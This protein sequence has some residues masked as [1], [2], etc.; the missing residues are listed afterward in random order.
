MHLFVCSGSPTIICLRRRKHASALDCTSKW[1]VNIYYSTGFPAFDARSVCSFGFPSSLGN[2]IDAF[3]IRFKNKVNGWSLITRITAELF[4]TH[5]R[6]NHISVRVSSNLAIDASA[7]ECKKCF[8][9]KTCIRI[10][11]TI[12]H[13]LFATVVASMGASQRRKSN[14]H[15]S[16]PDAFIT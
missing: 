4:T 12:N 3:W 6:C 1:F 7:N 8:E 13:T 16:W 9:R 11:A 15:C 10:N 14:S 5:R 2:R